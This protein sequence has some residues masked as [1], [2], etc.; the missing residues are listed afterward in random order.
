MAWGLD[1]ES[2]ME[3]IKK[4]MEVII[5]K[6]FLLG[7][8]SI[9]EWAVPGVGFHVCEG[10]ENFHQEVPIKCLSFIR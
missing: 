1:L 10:I 9:F 5:P 3:P 4:V 2:S 8:D 7:M 6:E